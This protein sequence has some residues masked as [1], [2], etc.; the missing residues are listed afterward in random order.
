MHRAYNLTTFMCQLSR[1][2]GS[3]HL[4][5]PSGPVQACNGLAPP[6]MVVVSHVK[7]TL[8]QL[9]NF[10]CFVTAPCNNI[11][12]L[13][14][15]VQWDGQSEYYRV[16]LLCVFQVEISYCHPEKK[17]MRMQNGFFI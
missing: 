10:K 5:E 4:L 3:S 14:R 1:N 15:Q 13:Y 9:Y 7:Q 2:S 8:L 17:L 12:S 6:S 16:T 11:S